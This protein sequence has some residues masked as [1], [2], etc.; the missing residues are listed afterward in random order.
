LVVI[1]IDWAI[2]RSAEMRVAVLQYQD[3]GMCARLAGSVVFK[4]SVLGRQLLHQLILLR[5]DALPVG[6]K[7]ILT[8]S[9]RKY[10]LALS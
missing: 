5:H 7:L 2:I 6:G 8:V 4:Q 10:G 3:G 1:G 9:N